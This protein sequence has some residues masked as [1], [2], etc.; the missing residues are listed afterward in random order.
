M[1]VFLST[2]RKQLCT[3]NCKT[4][5]VDSTQRQHRWFDV[6]RTL[7]KSSTE[8]RRSMHRVETIPVDSRVL[9]GD[10][11]IL[12]PDGI[13]QAHYGPFDR[14]E[15]CR[16]YNIG[17][18]DLRK[19]D[20]DLRIN[21]PAISVRHGKFI[22]F[23]FRRHRAVVQPHRSV[24]FVPSI[25]KIPFEPFGIKNVAEWEKITH[26]Y[27]RNVRYI[28]QVYNQRYITESTKSLSHMPFELQIMEIIGESIAY[29]LKL[30]TQDILM[31]FE[32][33]RQSSYARISIDSLRELG[34]IK[35]KV[36]RHH[37]NA[38]LAHQA[39]LD[40]L[41]YDQNMMGLYLTENRQSDSSDLSDVEL[42]LESCAKQIAE[43]CR[44]IYDL[45]DSVQ[46]VESTT[47]FMLDAVRN[48]LLAFEIRINIITMGFGIGAFITAIYGMNLYSGMEEH[49]RALLYV[50][51]ISSCFAI[52]SIVVGTYRLFKYRRVKL[53]RPNQTTLSL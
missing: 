13:L 48:H 12:T 44:S 29:G 3:I 17:P 9:N 16:E 28:H 50:A 21:V 20:P 33:I 22:L 42:I 11:H 27:R 19:L 35:S 24:F 46:T 14:A 7:S 39:W 10:I 41:S 4:L 25:E 37:R 1:S 15:I 32:T 30:K 49:P 45:K 5:F 18:R 38:D 31:E 34:F 26:A 43:V 6:S 47:G 51:A 2:L 53:H 8:L 40:L 52:T 36:D 23:S